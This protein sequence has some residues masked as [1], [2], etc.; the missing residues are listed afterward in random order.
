M[1]R[2]VSIMPGM[3]NFAPERTDTSSGSSAWPSFL[4]IFCSRAS[5]CWETSARSAAGSV[6]LSR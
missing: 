4:P 3:E 6:P 1:L 2:T 5:R